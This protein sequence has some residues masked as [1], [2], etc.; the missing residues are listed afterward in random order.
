MKSR[1]AKRLLEVHR[2]NGAD[3][4][5]P[6][7]KEALQQARRDPALGESFADQHDFDS[8]FA[9]DFKSAP[10]PAD[11]K[12]SILA[13]RKTVKLPLW[14][15]WR[16]PAAAAVAACFLIFAATGRV[17]ATERAE[18][19]PQFRAGL[20]EE[21]WDG[22]AHLDFESSDVYRVRQWLA[23][24]NAASD[25]SLPAGLRDCRV[26]GCRIV[27]TD[28]RRVPMICLSEGLKHMHLFVIDGAQF[29]DLPANGAPDFQRCGV[30]KTAS[31][32][33][34]N[35]TYVLTGLKYQAFVTKFRKSGR[36][37]MSG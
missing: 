6:Q 8:A 24:Q 37:T 17:P 19:F 25:F 22:Q 35:R 20:I 4:A 29:V 31:W 15:D 13:G 21:A 28:G 5:D 3:A 12:D 27:E 11:L 14:R 18:P 1:E 23:Q 30:W 26:I 16:L 34:G 9:Q 33:H 2:P 36:W 32:Q 7:M 10:V